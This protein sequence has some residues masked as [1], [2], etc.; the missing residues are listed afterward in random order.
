MRDGHNHFPLIVFRF[1]Q[2][3]KGTSIFDLLAITMSLIST[4]QVLL[5]MMA[6]VATTVLA[7][8]LFNL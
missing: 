5:I 4:I 2:T 6:L 1:E 7:D 8:A 3:D